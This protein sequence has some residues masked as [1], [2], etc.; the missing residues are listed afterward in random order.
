MDTIDEE[1]NEGLQLFTFLFI[2]LN[3]LLIILLKALLD[4]GAN[5]YLA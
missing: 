5:L 3:T 1:I 4:F 2:L